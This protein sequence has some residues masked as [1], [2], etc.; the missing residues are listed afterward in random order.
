[1][2]HAV[3]ARLIGLFTI[4]AMILATALIL[5][6]GGGNAFS[7]IPRYVVYFEGSVNG[8]NNGAA[9]KLKGVTIGRVNEVLVQ[10][11][12]E[13]NRV[14]T[15]VIAEIDLKKVMETHGNDDKHDHP[16]LKALIDRGLRA[17]L[18]LTSLVTNQLY[19]EIDFMPD[20]PLKLMGSEALDLP[21]IPAVPSSKDDI[22]KTVQHLSH[23]VQDLPLKETVDATLG[24]IRHLDKLLTKPE[25]SA[26]V[27]HLNQTLIDLQRLLKRLDGMTQDSQVLVKQLNQEI[28][29]LLSTATDTL[30][31][32]KS[33]LSSVAALTEP[34]A[35]LQRTLHDLSDAAKAI[36]RLADAIERHPDALLIG[37]DQA[38]PQKP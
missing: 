8:L 32:A 17:R 2:S 15:P 10:Y 18:S 31:E 29:P 23:E 38:E 30:K 1:M 11:D 35:E 28:P 20:R 16:D 27:D 19:V 4:G 25:T 14:L 33:A 3:S 36:R 34:D 26:S 21:E 12:A 22:E 9:V 13:H 6:F 5:T 37:R 24:A 7:K